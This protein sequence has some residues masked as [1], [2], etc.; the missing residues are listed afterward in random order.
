MRPLRLHRFAIPVLGVLTLLGSVW[1][2]KAVGAWQVSGRGQVLLDASG[3]ADPAGIKGWMTLG[4]VSESYGVPLDALYEMIGASPDLPP[5]TE[6]REL[7]KLV[8][9]AEVSAIRLGVAGYREESLTAGE[10]EGGA[11]SLEPQ[12]GPVEPGP[13]V[14]GASDHAPEGPGAGNGEGR[15]GGVSL[16]EDGGPLPGSEI[17]GWM[18]LQDVVDLCQ[19]PLDVLIAELDLPQDVD[20]SLAMRDLASQMGIEVGSVREAVVRYQAER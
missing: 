4:F 11:G 10:A 17:R 7:E 6:L 3:E 16:P 19:V 1:I 9:G 13:R 14:E 12:P 5:E 8:P 18:T 20:S 2:A 15:G